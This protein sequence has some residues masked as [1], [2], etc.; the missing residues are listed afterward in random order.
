MKKYTRDELIEKLIED[1]IYIQESGDAPDYLFNILKS[2]FKG[3]D[4]YTEG[5]LIEE[6]NTRTDEEWSFVK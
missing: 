3:Y 6:Y 5:E 2:G 1:D 4:R